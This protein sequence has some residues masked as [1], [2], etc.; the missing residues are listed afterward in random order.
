MPGAR[1][2]AQRLGAAVSRSPARHLQR[3]ADEGESAA[4]SAQPALVRAG[5][6]RRLPTGRPRASR[7][8]TQG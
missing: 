3:N 7:R 2:R 6:G 5:P 4:E 1:V 8:P